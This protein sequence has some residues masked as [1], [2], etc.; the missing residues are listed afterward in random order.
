MVEKK[1]TITVNLEIFSNLK[2]YFLKNNFVLTFSILAFLSV[3]IGI[4]KLFEVPLGIPFLEQLIG[5]FSGG[6]WFFF[7]T[8]S[9]LSGILAYHKKFKLMFIP[10]LIWLLIIT[11]Y[12]RTSNIPLLI[13]AATGEPVLGPDLDPFL[14]L[15]HAEDIINGENL[16]DIDYMRYAPIGAPSYLKRSLMPWTIVGIYYVIN[17]FG[18]YSVTQAAIITP[19][20]LFI[21]SLIGFF[22][23]T[24]VLFSFKLSEKKSL[25]GATI[26]SFF[27]AFIPSMLHRTTAGIP[28]I[29][30]LGMV[31]FWLAFLFF[32]LAWKQKVPEENR[33]KNKV[34][35]KIIIL[36]LISGLFT[37]LMS[38]SWGGYTYIYMVISLATFLGFLFNIQFKKNLTIFS[39]FLFLG[40]LGEFLKYNGFFSIKESL[41]IIATSFNDTGF[42]LGVFLILIGNFILFSSKIKDTRG[43]KIIKRK[44]NLPENLLTILILFI[45]LIVFVLISNPGVFSDFVLNIAGRL[46]QPFGES[47]IGLTVAENRAPY[48]NEIL[49]SF[50]IL[51]WLFLIGL[52]LI[53]YETIKNF[54]L[55]KRLMLLSSFILFLFAITFSRISNNH[56]LDGE[57]LISKI[58]FFG[59]FILFGGVALYT[60]VLSWLE[61]KSK[62]DDTAFKK[63]S[64]I[65]IT[66]LIFISFGFWAIISMR[67]AVRLFFIIGPMV[68]LISVYFFIKIMDYK[69]T[70][71]ELSKIFL[72]VT[73]F[74]SILILGLSFLTYA[75]STILSA[76]NMVPSVYNQQW[77]N[78]MYWVSE[79]T[80]EGAIFTHWWDYGYWVQTLGKRPT[81][82]DGQHITNW[83]DHTVGRY[84]LTSPTPETALS[85]MKSH[86][87]SYL[88]IDSTDIGKYAAFSTIGSDDTG[89]DRR[90]WIPIMPLE[91]SQVYETGNSTKLLFIGGT[92]LDGDIIYNQEE[93]KQLFLPENKAGLGGIILE[94]STKEEK[95]SFSQPKGI[96]VYNNQRYDLPL[97]YLYYNNQIIDF[98]SGVNS[99]IKIVPGL[100]QD[101][102][103]GLSISQ[104]GAVMYLSEKTKDS[105]LVQLYLLDDPENLYPTLKIAHIEDD[106]IIKNLKQQGID[107]G[108][109]VYYQ[110]LRGPIKIWE[111]NFPGNI[112]KREEFLE[113][114]P[115]GF[116]PVTGPWATL[117]NLSFSV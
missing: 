88:L 107:L 30:S 36:G 57:N 79:N 29:E 95:V 96:F 113:F 8:M 93:G 26:A 80:P 83:W 32:A 15:R 86:N 102:K 91:P 116:N 111:V 82:S 98:N 46:L 71:E 2:N 31:W 89:K 9:A 1:D 78:A 69:K 38:W 65:D 40:V 3:L 67:G 27:Y 112:L 85:L 77:H 92:A 23:F 61:K 22:F 5:L 100:S 60:Y 20:I 6:F 16:G 109:F 70:K 13:N 66:Y 35:I 49:G 41:I 84:L 10:I 81:V 58:L 56:L 44:I 33:T 90:S 34:K 62:K 55:K 73:I 12:V 39:S 45:L 25:T 53:F 110:G 72:G 48:F 115:E 37:G 18:E 74:L 14:Y 105:L 117:D 97:R 75:N 103:Q 104:M 68:I 19:V 106:F 11:V 59:G 24:Y 21:L 108:S 42:A 94:Y 54:D 63:F 50:G 51:I 28:E 7:S 114:L 52:I 43:I 47:R 4:L 64:E 76:S 17:I 87:V 99:M 101:N